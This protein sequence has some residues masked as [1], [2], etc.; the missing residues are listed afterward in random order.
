MTRSKTWS[1]GSAVVVDVPERLGVCEDD[2]SP[3]GLTLLTTVGA[4]DFDNLLKA[5]A[6]AAPKPRAS[7][8]RRRPGENSSSPA[9]MVCGLGAW[10]SG[11][12]VR[13][14]RRD[15]RARRP[16]LLRAPMS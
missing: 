7:N 14:G 1:G 16:H 5:K 6:L 12:A 2:A 4:P 8:S 10:R 9:V 13:P 15:R 3:R 11:P